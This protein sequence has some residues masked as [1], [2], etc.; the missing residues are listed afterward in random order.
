MFDFWNKSDNVKV[1]GPAPVIEPKGIT[2]EEVH[3]EFMTASEKLIKDVNDHLLKVKANKAKRLERFG[4]FQSTDVVASADF[5]KKQRLA[6]I[7]QKYQF[8]HPNNKVLTYESMLM[9]CKKY[10]L[11]HANVSRYTGFVPEKNLKEIEE[12]KFQEGF[13]VYLDSHRPGQEKPFG[14]FK[15]LDE[16][17]KFADGKNED[18]QKRGGWASYMVDDPGKRL[19]IC[20]PKDKIELRHGERIEGNRI[21][22]P[23]PIVLHEIEE[24]CFLIVTA[25]G[26]E[27]SDPEVINEKMN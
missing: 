19:T 14:P 1:T 2:V 23:D 7:I 9:I 10:N 13:M 4:F 21:V 12:F 16:A 27:A 3:R 24:N 20:A 17:Q 6:E 18:T 8:S 15:T 5:L 25:W 11:V 22:V 26:E